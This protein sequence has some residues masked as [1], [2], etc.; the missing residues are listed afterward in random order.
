METKNK[1]IKCEKGEQTKMKNETDVEK[2]VEK[3]MELFPDKILSEFSPE[4][5][6]KILEENL[7]E[8]N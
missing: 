5:Y 2:L 1:N 7:K 8:E 3:S 4:E 6:A